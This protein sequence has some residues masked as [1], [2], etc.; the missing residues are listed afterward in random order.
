MVFSFQ[1]WHGGTR[2]RFNGVKR[3]LFF[4]KEEFLH[5]HGGETPPW[6]KKHTLQIQLLLASIMSVL[7]LL[8]KKIFGNATMISFVE[9]PADLS[10]S[11]HLRTTRIYD[12]CLHDCSFRYPI[13]DR[14]VRWDLVFHHWK[15]FRDSL[16]SGCQVFNIPDKAFLFILLML[17]RWLLRPWQNCSL[18][19]GMKEAHHKIDLFF[20]PGRCGGVAEGNS[21]HSWLKRDFHWNR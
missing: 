10:V 18:N 5:Q 14:Q 2:P 1:T 11:T 20:V 4:C 15:I 9:T 7:S 6:R 17:L 21:R 3:T 16:L 8:A 12:E 19:T 13:S